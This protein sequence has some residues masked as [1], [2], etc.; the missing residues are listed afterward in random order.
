MKT[1]NKNKRT[2]SDYIDYAMK[3][4]NNVIDAM[5]M[6]DLMYANGDNTAGKA[7]RKL[8]TSIDNWS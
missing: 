6:L 4:T 1:T 5:I 7:S 3:A 8:Q 2:T